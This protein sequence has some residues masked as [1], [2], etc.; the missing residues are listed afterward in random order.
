MGEPVARDIGA[1]AVCE[2]E[3]RISTDKSLA[4]YRDCLGSKRTGEENCSGRGSFDRGDLKEV[5]GAAGRAMEPQAVFSGF[6]SNGCDRM[7]GGDR[8]EIGFDLAD[9]AGRWA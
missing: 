5:A 2:P 9:F 8:V 6:G 1:D 7:A 4:P 3:H